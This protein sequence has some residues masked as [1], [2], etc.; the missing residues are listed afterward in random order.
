MKKR[1]QQVSVLAERAAEAADA[2]RVLANQHRLLLLC[3]L[4]SGERSVGEL[5]DQLQLSQANVS[6]HLGKLRAGGMVATRREGTT[7]YYRLA[8]EQAEQL[9][10]MLCERFGPPP[11]AT[12]RRSAS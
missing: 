8:D 4:S 3:H 6:Q 5:V 1:Q 7:I 12:R 10:D 9:I 2:L 11:A